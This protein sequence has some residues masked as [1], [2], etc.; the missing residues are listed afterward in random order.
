MVELLI[1]NNGKLLAPVVKDGISW[2]T[3]RKGV[4]GKLSFTVIPDAGLGVQEGNPVRLTVDGTPIFY[5]FVFTKKR[6]RDG[7]FAI[8]AYDQ[9]RYLKNKDC[10]LYTGKRADEVLSMI[11]KDY[12]LQTGTLDNTGYVIPKKDES[13]AELFDVIQNALDETLMN[14]NKLYVLYDDFGKLCLRDVEQ[15][16]IPLVING[17][18][19]EDF[20]YTSTIDS[21]VYNRIKLAY[22]NGDTGLRDVYVSQDSEKMNQWGVLQYYEDLTNP[23][24]GKAKADALLKLY[25]LKNRS[26]S[27]SG[28]LGDPRVRAGTSVVVNLSFGDARVQG[29]MLAEAAKH[30]FTDGY[31]KMDLTLRG[32]GFIG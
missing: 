32:G 13:G 25:N 8:T 9:L 27:I 28:A 7:H 21:N 15:L 30:E 2:E 11:A 23:T 17:E 24:S 18:T 31:H 16:L 19:A 6:S 1:E 20:N 10:Y 14:R 29:Y 26:L 3:E 12:N 22:D 5:G 4:P